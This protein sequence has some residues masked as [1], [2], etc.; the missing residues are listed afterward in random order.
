[1]TETPR[2]ILAIRDPELAQ[3]TTA[4]LAPGWVMLLGG[5]AASVIDASM[6]LSLEGWVVFVHI[7]M[8]RGLGRDADGL[9]VLSRFGAPQGVISTHPSVVQAA[10][11]LGFATSLRIFLVD[12]GSLRSGI[13]Q[14][15]RT[16]PDFVEILP[17]VLPHLIAPVARATGLPVIPGG[18][19]TTPADAWAAIEGGALAISTSSLEVYRAVVEAPAPLAH[20]NHVQ[21]SRGHR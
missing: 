14:A 13:Q 21:R 17:G 9:G 5:P 1:M 18:L 19:I 11:D 8:V 2:A 6:T 12:S 4:G 15:Q 10:R 20:E 16:K 3:A 7:D